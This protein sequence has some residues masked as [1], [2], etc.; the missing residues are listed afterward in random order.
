MKDYRRAHPAFSLCGLN[1]ALCPMRLDGYCPGCGG[2]EGHQGCAFIRCSRAHGG[3]EFCCRCGE[4]PCGR[5]RSAMEFDSF[6]PHRHMVSDV[7]RA[8]EMGMDAYLAV[9]EEKAQVLRA[10]LEGYNDGRR[11]RFFCTAVNLLET[12]DLRGVMAEL[13]EGPP[14]AAV[15]ERAALAVRL[16]QARGV[17]RGLTL[18]L[19]RRPKER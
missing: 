18:K 7:M 4:F 13:A 14:D 12:E 15:Q 3:V 2:G 11:K 17:S 19:N 1:C 16:L 6:V 8:G 10:L 9:L 5:I